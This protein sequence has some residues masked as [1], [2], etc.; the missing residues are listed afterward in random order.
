MRVLPTWGN[1]KEK[2][3]KH[4]KETKLW[5]MRPENNVI[6]IRETPTAAAAVHPARPQVEIKKKSYVEFRDRE[7]C[8]FSFFRSRIESDFQADVSL[9][10]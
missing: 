3:N 9:L 10:Q 2:M 4:S 7:S 5:E 1:G 6:F 8:C